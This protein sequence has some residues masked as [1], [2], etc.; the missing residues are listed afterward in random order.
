M[1]TSEPYVPALGVRWLT[2]FYDLVIRVSLREGHIKSALVEQVGLTPGQR[3]L[4][5]GAGTGTL[6]LMLKRAQPEADVIG[7]DGDLEIL[8]IARAKATQSGLAVSFDEGMADALPYPD[9]SF[10]RVVSSLVFHHLSREAKRRAVGEAFRVL[11]PGGELHVADWGRPHNTLMQVLAVAVQWLDGFDRVADN[12]A[13]RLPEF[14][15]EGGFVDVQ[16]TAHYATLFGT[17]TF[18]RAKK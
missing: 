9:G 16:E 11:K 1:N 8:A 6:T 3:A 13:G 2:R 10:D 12:L 14:F 4:D 5:L 7:L 17:L 15:R 18:Y